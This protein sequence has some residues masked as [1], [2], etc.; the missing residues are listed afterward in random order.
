MLDFGIISKEIGL[1]HNIKLYAMMKGTSEFMI[2]FPYIPYQEKTLDYDFTPLLKN[3][4]K[5]VKSDTNSQLLGTIS[6]SSLVP[7]SYSGKIF[8]CSDID[9]KKK[10]FI[11]YSAT[12][13]KSPPI[14]KGYQTSLRAPSFEIGNQIKK[15]KGKK[16]AIMT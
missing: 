7:G 16:A 13:I 11:E 6:F 1:T 3:G 14:L 2:G 15:S 12:V 4:G 5:I 8:F 10:M 9:C